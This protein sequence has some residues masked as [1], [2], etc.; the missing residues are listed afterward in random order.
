MWVLTF[1]L[2]VIAGCLIIGDPLVSMVTSSYYL[3]MVGIT[4]LVCFCANKMV[5]SDNKVLTNIGIG[6][7]IAIVVLLI[8][9][10][11]SSGIREWTERIIGFEAPQ[12]SFKNVSW[13]QWL[14]WGG[15]N[16]IIFNFTSPKDDPSENASEPANED[17]VK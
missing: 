2:D 10:L 6:T 3:S 12:I 5:K 16:L 15:V 1:I 7:W 8:L 11:T 9:L 13:F 14:L 17:N 4:L